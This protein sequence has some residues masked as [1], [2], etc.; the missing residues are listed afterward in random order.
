MW[1][2][3]SLLLQTAQPVSV[4]LRQGGRL[5]LNLIWII[6]GNKG[7][8]KEKGMKSLRSGCPLMFREETDASLEWEKTWEQHLP[9]MSCTR[10]TSKWLRIALTRGHT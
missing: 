5:Y 8:P 9:A 4:R 1:G 7:I 10:V 2:R 3:L 6:H